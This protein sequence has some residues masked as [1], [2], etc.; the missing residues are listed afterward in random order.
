LVELLVVIAIIGILIAL[1]LPAIQAARES[2]RRTECANNL[3]QIGVAVSNFES[4]HGYLPAGAEWEEGK[5]ARGSALIFILPYLD[6]TV[7][8][9][10]YDFKKENVDDE[11]YPGTNRRIGA[12][13]IP[14]YVCPSDTYES[15]EWPLHNYS[16]SRGP[17]DV[18]DNPDCFCDFPWRKFAM[19]PDGDRKNFAGP[20][21]RLGTKCT[22]RQITDGMSKTIFFGEIRPVC[23]WHGLNG[24]AKSNNGNGYCSTLTPINFDTCNADAVDPCHRPCNWNTEAGFRSFH[25][26]GA[27]FLMGDGAVRMLDENIDYMTYQYL[28]AKNDGHVNDNSS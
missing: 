27:N 22:L 26:G 16:A 24:W 17:T 10:A 18:G 11:V 5:I 13:S 6:E 8:Y 9:Q 19:A 1:L 2:A 4:T 28:G 23:S 25:V 12:T 14:T 20:F 3:R 15:V 21:S 7:I